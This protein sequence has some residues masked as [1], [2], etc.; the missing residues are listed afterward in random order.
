MLS[1]L[2]V[3]V[4]AFGQTD[5]F[6]QK[7]D[8][9]VSRLGP[10]G[11]GVETVLDNWEKADSTDVKMLLGKFRLWF[12]KS[13]KTVVV[14][15]P[16]NTYLGA[17]PV[18]TLKD[19]TGAD[20]NYFEDVEYDD[21]LYGKAVR[22]IDRAVSMWPDRLDLRFIKANALIAYEKES[23]DMTL[24]YLLDLADIDHGRS[25]PWNY[26]E[27]KVEDSF[28]AD[29]ILEYCY[30]FYQIGSVSSRKA[31]LVL[32][33]K[34]Y[35]FYPDNVAYLNNI[36]AWHMISK[37]FKKALKC[38]DKVLKKDPG[39]QVALQNALRIAKIQKNAKREKKYMKM[40]GN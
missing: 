2:S 4:Q 3:C 20:V 22:Y 35:G 32:S 5:G 15:K 7:Y 12:D 31:F 34:M 6:E 21:E 30:T 25:K 39:N 27:R 24:A 40:M 19:S 23:P 16:G 33:E 9:L 37:D 26:E 38:Y 11:V 8:M 14:P 1:V 28:F 13:A 29:S 36:G 10:S 17:R 18:L